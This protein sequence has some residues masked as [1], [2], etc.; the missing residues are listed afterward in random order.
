MSTAINTNAI[1][2]SI[3]IE[4]TATGYELGTITA[5]VESI[6]QILDFTFMSGGNAVVS[7]NGT[8]VG[9]Y[10]DVRNNDNINT[11]TNFNHIPEP[12]TAALLGGLGLL[13]L[14][15]RRR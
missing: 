4:R 15:R 2:D 7:A 11:L 3:Y 5:N 1:P 13:T 9:I 12:S 10:S 8:A 6:T 14:L